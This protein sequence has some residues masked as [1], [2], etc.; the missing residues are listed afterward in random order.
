MNKDDHG[1]PE[2]LKDFVPRP[3][4]PHL[5]TKVLAAITTTPPA[6]RFLTPGQWRMAAACA[7]PMIGALAG[8]ALISRSLAG[9]L[10]IL[11]NKSQAASS[12]GDA[13]RAG[14]E[15][16]VGID[17]AR[18]LRRLSTRPRHDRASRVE[19]Q[20]DWND[21]ALEEKE[22]ADVHSKNPR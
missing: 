10:D 3:A 17:Q 15:E 13:D 5:R 7:L 6:G 11:L 1:L 22:D 19:E 16:L 18:S 4:P 21:R 12:V 8:D 9:R 20:M 14:L 2:E